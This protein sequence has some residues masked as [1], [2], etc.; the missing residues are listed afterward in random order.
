[1]GGCPRILVTGPG[2][3]NVEIAA[4]QCYLSSDGSDDCAGKKA[5]RYV[6]ATANQRIE[7]W[8]SIFRRSCTSWWINF[9]RDLSDDG[10]YL[11]GDTYHDECL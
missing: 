2:T 6:G 7:C 3:E 10:V 4:L 5:H 9:F 8:W 11:H 1:M